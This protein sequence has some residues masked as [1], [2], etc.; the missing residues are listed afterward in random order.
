MIANCMFD[1][2]AQIKWKFVGKTRLSKKGLLC[3]WYKDVTG[4]NFFKSKSPDI[5]NVAVSS[6]KKS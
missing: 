2:I 6:F 5:D 3:F 4:I 1:T